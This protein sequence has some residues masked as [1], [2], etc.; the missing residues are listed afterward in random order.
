M[1]K[2][3]TKPIAIFTASSLLKTDACGRPRT[4]PLFRRRRLAEGR[5]SEPPAA[6]QR[7]QLSL[8]LQPVVENWGESVTYS[9]REHNITGLLTALADHAQAGE[10]AQNSYADMVWIENGQA[11]LTYLGR[12]EVA[13]MTAALEEADLLSAND[14]ECERTIEDLADLKLMS[15]AWRTSVDPEHGSLRFYCDWRDFGGVIEEWSC[16]QRTYGHTKE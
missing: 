15:G 8:C 3:R 4:L 12:T 13:D 16:N 5:R 7:S 6:R 10:I 2:L 11:F 14:V 1:M 9:S